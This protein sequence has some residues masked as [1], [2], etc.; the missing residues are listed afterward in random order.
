[1]SIAHLNIPQ[2][3]IIENQQEIGEGIFTDCFQLPSSS[4]R[5]NHTKWFLVFFHQIEAA[6]VSVFEIVCK[7]NV[8]TRIKWWTK[9]S[10]LRYYCLILMGIGLWRETHIHSHQSHTHTHIYT[11]YRLTHIRGGRDAVNDGETAKGKET[12]KNTGMII[13]VPWYL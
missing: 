4:W 12:W 3:K 10:R 9:C 5:Y 13:E 1:M 6:A 2:I 11:Y 7:W 8:L